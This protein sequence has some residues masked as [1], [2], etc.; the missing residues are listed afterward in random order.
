GVLTGWRGLR[1]L[2]GPGLL[3]GLGGAYPE[4]A[5]RRLPQCLA[6]SHRTGLAVAHRGLRGGPFRTRLPRPVARH[7]RGVRTPDAGRLSP[8]RVYA[9][10]PSHRESA[11]KISPQRHGRVA[12]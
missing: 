10:G 6:A 11:G 5:D 8:R 9:D 3:T 7:L 4:P 12:V 2:G 1:S